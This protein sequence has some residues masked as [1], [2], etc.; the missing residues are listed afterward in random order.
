LS[1]EK[2]FCGA[3]RNGISVAQ[4][5][6]VVSKLVS[7]DIASKA[8]LHDA[9]EAYLKDLQRPLKALWGEQYDQ[10]T[11]LAMTAICDSLDEPW[12]W[13]PAV[14]TAIKVVDDADLA[15]ERRDQMRAD[16]PDWGEYWR[17]VKAAD[18]C[19]KT[20]WPEHIAEQMFLRRWKELTTEV[21]ENTEEVASA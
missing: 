7:P 6:G 12:P 19:Y 13:P 14:V 18:V 16:G 10:L 11:E 9:A 2:R 15:A 8:Q 20:P 1:I 17:T 4:H 21:T 3:T 5:S